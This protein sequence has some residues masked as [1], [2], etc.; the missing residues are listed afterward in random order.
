MSINISVI[1]SINQAANLLGVNNWQLQTAKFAGVSFFI[2]PNSWDKF[3]PLQPV[4]QV[5]NQL[6]N[7][8][9]PNDALSPDTSLT[10]QNIRDI[11]TRKLALYRLPNYNGFV[12]NDQGS[13]GVVYEFTGLFIGSDYLTAINNFR[14]AANQQSSTGFEFIHPIYGAL[15]NC[16]CQQFNFIYNFNEW[17]AAT[18]NIRIVQS[19]TL[20]ITNL[21]VSITQ[22]L[23]QILSDINLSIN[24]LNTIPSTLLLSRS[25]INGVTGGVSGNTTVSLMNTPI[26]LSTNVATSTEISKLIGDSVSTTSQ[27]LNA[28]TSL[29]YQQLL[30]NQVTNYTFANNIIDYNNLPPIYRYATIKP[31]QFDNLL[32]YYSN[33]VDNSIN[34]Y[35]QYKL[36]TV[37]SSDILVLKQ[38]LAQ[39]DTLLKTILN[40]IEQ[41]YTT[42]TLPYTMSYRTLF[43]LNGLSFNNSTLVQTFI[44]ANI[45]ILQDLNVI[46]KDTIVILPKG[47]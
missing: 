19:K 14:N 25:I 7:D 29:V 3:N 42:Y 47:T 39:L 31:A 21:E 13:D 30:F 38:S 45:N 1:S 35:I 26:V 32:Q 28:T 10:L 2:V 6:F 22:I 9:D 17:K 46:Y 8:D 5:A 43:Y 37:F 41:T 23:S 16:Y 11:Q 4:F 12:V 20:V 18:F 40:Q 27:V 24:S 33:N 44:D 36:D 15:Q 34:L